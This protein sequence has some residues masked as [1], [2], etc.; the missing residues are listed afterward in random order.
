M[1]HLRFFLWDSWHPWCTLKALHE[2]VTMFLGFRLSV[3]YVIETTIPLIE[4]IHGVVVFWRHYQG[5]LV[6]YDD[7]FSSW[8]LTVH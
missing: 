8:L 1:S 7:I 2:L 5:V 4:G 6:V 3:K